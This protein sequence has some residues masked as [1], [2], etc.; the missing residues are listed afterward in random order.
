VMPSPLGFT[1]LFSS[2]SI[3]SP[4]TVFFLLIYIQ[5]STSL[6]CHHHLAIEKFKSPVLNTC[7]TQRGGY[8]LTKELNGRIERNCDGNGI[9]QISVCKELMDKP[10]VIPRETVYDHRGFTSDGN[11]RRGGGGGCAISS[12]YPCTQGSESR[13]KSVS[14]NGLPFKNDPRDQYTKATH[15]RSTSDSSHS[16]FI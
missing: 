8:C 7:I 6:F 13:I 9:H 5:S 4:S 16:S 10:V 14:P 15:A 11:G 2:R 3:I 12:G 1:S